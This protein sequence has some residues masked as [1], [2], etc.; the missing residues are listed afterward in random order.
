MSP[1]FNST[2]SEKHLRGMLETSRTT[3]AIA[4]IAQMLLVEL[5]GLLF[6]KQ[7]AS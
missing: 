4:L 1:V 2:N 3:L 7:R 6:M 5:L